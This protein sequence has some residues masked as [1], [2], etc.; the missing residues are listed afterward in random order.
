M[1]CLQET[2]F[3]KIINAQNVDKNM[4]S[5]E[6]FYYSFVIFIERK[7]VLTVNL[8]L[9]IWFPLQLYSTKEERKFHR[10]LAYLKLY[11]D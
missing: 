8:L 6:L 7:S 5:L 11:W 2:G 3:Q 10:K 4:L 1:T 9:I